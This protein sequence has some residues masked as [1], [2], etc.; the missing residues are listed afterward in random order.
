MKIDN[1]KF[2]KAARDNDLYAFLVIQRKETPNETAP[3]T[4][5][6]LGIRPNNNHSKGGALVFIEAETECQVINHSW[7]N[8]DGNGRS[9][10]EIVFHESVYGYE[11]HIKTFL[12]SIKRDSDVRFKI[13]A[14]NCSEFDRQNELVAHELYGIID[15]K[16]Y[17]LSYYKGADNL[18]SPIR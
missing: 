18:A 13:L 2:F 9:F 3:R 6:W 12:T 15:R 10:V 8:S 1:P 16:Y 5:I 11:N 14:F 7:T 4:Y 17:L